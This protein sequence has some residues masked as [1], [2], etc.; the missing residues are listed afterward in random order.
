MPE[1][2][3]G[4]LPNTFGASLPQENSNSLSNRGREVMLGTEGRHGDLRWDISGNLAW[5]RQKWNHYEEP[6]YSD[7]DQIRINRQSG[8]WTDLVFGYRSDGL[9]TSTEE[10]QN[11]PFDQDLQGNSTLS[12]GDVKYIDVKEDGKLDWLDQVVNG[13]G[14][15]PRWTYG[16]STNLQYKDFDLAAL[17]QGAFDH[18]V[19]V[20][21][22]TSDAVSP[23]VRYELRWT[24]EN[25]NP[26]AL[27]PRLGGSGLNNAASDYRRKSAAY[28][29]LKQLSF[30]YNIPDNVTRRLNVSGVR[31]DLAGKN[32]FTKIGKAS[33]RERVCQN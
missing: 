29:R 20:N 13:K 31:V 14:S 32:L 25:N 33:C 7:P 27:E 5:S 1:T 30:G 11:L 8:R 2:R 26:N 24:E 17:M 9:F 3:Q 21:L 22:K 10:I 12:P 18:S 4:S 6:E 28:I 16:I 23:A 19:L 15:T